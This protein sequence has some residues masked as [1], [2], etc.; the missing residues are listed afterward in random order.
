ME[1]RDIKLDNKR[2]IMTVMRTNGTLLNAS[3]YKVDIQTEFQLDT[4]E[5]SKYI[6]LYTKSGA[7]ER[8]TKF[9]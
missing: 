9:D 3:T 2:I 1:S 8:E 5:N 4:R 7:S 6:Q